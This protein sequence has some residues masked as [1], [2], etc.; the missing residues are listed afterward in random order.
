MASYKISRK[1]RKAIRNQMGTARSSGVAP[2]KPKR[3][4]SFVPGDLVQLNRRG[5]DRS[6]QDKDTWGVIVSPY[7]DG[8]YFTVMTPNGGDDW[9]GSWMDRVQQLDQAEETDPTDV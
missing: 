8:D 5:A 7:G 1:Q 4:W 9:H 6:H 2:P 3:Q